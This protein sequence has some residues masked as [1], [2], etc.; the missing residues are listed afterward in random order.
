[1]NTKLFKAFMAV[2]LL[3]GPS[4]LLHS[5]DASA[6]TV[7][8]GALRGEIKDKAANNEGAAGAT[9]VATSASLQGEQVV[10]TDEKG[11]YFIN[12]L[13]PGIYTLTI[14][15]SDRT[16]SRGNVQIQIGKEVVV[17]VTVDS[18]AKQSGGG[19]KEGKGEIIEIQGSA[20]IIDQGSTK[21]G[22]TLTDDYTRNIPTARTF[23]GVIG[24]AAGSQ[25]DIYGT[26]IAGA[27]SGENTYIVE[28][29]NTSDTGFGGLSSNLP[30]E[31][32]Q[33]TEVI[34]GG[35]NAEYGRATGGIINV[36]TKS[37]SN[38]FKGSVF[39][40]YKPGAFVSGA[41]TV[42]REGGSIDSANN[43][44]Y[45]YDLGAELGGPIIKDKLW[46]HVGVNPNVTQ[47]HTTRIVQSQIDE[48][49]DGV[50]DK[51]SKG[52]TKHEFVSRS[53]IPEN[54]KTYYF[55][56]KINGAINA[57]NQVQLSAFGNPRTAKDLNGITRN[58]ADT[59]WAYDDGAYDVSLKWTSKFNEGKTEVDAVAGYHRGFTTEKPYSSSQN[60]PEI[61]YNYER[62]LNDF[63]D[64]ENN[65]T[66]ATTGQ[67]CAD[68]PT[69]KYAKIR[70]CPVTAYREQGLGFLEE[71]VNDRASGI[72]TLTQRISTGAAG[73]HTFKGGLELESST[74][75][76][77]HYY[78]GGEILRRNAADTMTTQGRWQERTFVAYQSTLTAEQ[79]MTLANSTDPNP[80]GLTND[81]NL[82]SAG[83]AICKRAASIQADTKNRSIGSFLQDSWQVLPNFTLDLGVR[84]EQ[85]VG[86]AATALQGTVTGDGETVPDRAFTLNNLWSPRLGFVYDPTS[87]GKAKIFGHWGRFYENVPMDLNVRAFGGEIINFNVLNAKRRPTTDAMYDP[88]CHVDHGNPDL[89]SALGQCNDRASQ[90]TA[91]GGIEY[92]S[93]GFRGQY[94]DELIFGTEYEIM[95]DMKLGLNYIHR[96]LPNVIEDISTDGGT[97]YLITNP[98][99]NFDGEA[100]KLD[101]QSA[102]LFRDSGCKSLDDTTASCNLD[103]LGL[104]ALTESRANQLRA[105]KKFDKPVRNYDAV[106][107]T[108]TLRATKQSLILASYTYSVSKGNYPG[109]FS[110]E[111]GQNDP[112][113]TSLYDLPDLMANR[114]GNLGLDRP[115]NLKVDAFYVFDLKKAGLLTA[116]GSFRALSGIAHNVLG[117]SPHPGYGVG[118]SYLLPRGAAPRSPVTTQLD[119]H[120]AYGYPLSKTTKLEA[121][122][123]IFNLFNKQDELNQD[124]D[125]TN[126]FANPIV[127]G[128]MNDLK[129]VKHFDDAGGNTNTTVLKNKNFGNTGS[130]NG[131]ASL[132]A[133]RNVQLGFRLT[134]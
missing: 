127:G 109:L 73:Y 95:A 35:Y 91:G 86:Y 112:N 33:E 4:S 50:P 92:I 88:N 123:N 2:G 46:F 23:G 6:Q 5:T 40:Y 15:Y 97:N 48:N 51:D 114:Y 85:Q 63:A 74:Y 55:T 49:G 62:S 68:G 39:G 132:Q 20:P 90:G 29:I 75:N 17:N 83:R 118:E 44:N 47:A 120:L 66:N 64:L 19:G 96:S 61:F 70:N 32:I 1:M 21:I 102:Q 116:G 107:L 10:L 56:G 125:Y 3:A 13:P 103:K 58:P 25:G 59:R 106:Q 31:F 89:V 14:Y 113:I 77:K 41:K 121:F 82:C 115:H 129:H 128:D 101:Q 24:Q 27:T 36:V 52:F 18:A 80:L 104:S 30:N 76:A 9:V 57:N 94:T 124:E 131:G 87:E 69:D 11:L 45:N 81:Q 105:V 71:R 117:A 54:F 28:G 22:V 111:T 42:Q 72:I 110:T 38:E 119:V 100:T 98:G 60:V 37:G 67:S 133:P 93:P 122:V 78:T 126:D 26:S 34:T 7:T 12:A 134:F 130:S 16:F 108:S 53:E 99:N 65:L 84:Y 8:A 79:R 43:L